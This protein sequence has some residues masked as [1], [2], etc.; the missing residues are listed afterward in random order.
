MGNSDLQA[1]LASKYMTG[2]KADAILERSDSSNGA[3]KRKK[4]KVDTTLAQPVAS[5]SGLMVADEDDFGWARNDH[6]ED[7]DASRPGTLSST[8]HSNPVTYLT[9]ES[10]TCH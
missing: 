10:L 7:D 8:L 2:A 9:R 1:Y 3:K 6:D 4:R 5:G